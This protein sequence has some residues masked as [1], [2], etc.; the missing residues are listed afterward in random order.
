MNIYEKL[1]QEVLGDTSIKGDGSQYDDEEVQYPIDTPIG[2]RYSYISIYE[3]AYKCKIWT[4]TK[5]FNLVSST[6]YM[7]D[8]QPVCMVVAK[9]GCEYPYR[10]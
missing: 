5:G 7:G 9:D 3:L 2:I 4:E 6:S 1:L 10:R 8:G